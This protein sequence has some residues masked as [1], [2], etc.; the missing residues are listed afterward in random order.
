MKLLEKLKTTWS[1]GIDIFWAYFALWLARDGDIV[2]GKAI[3]MV[4][5]IK[6]LA[7]ASEQLLPSTLR[8]KLAA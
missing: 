8:S 1:R 3:L 5:E 6:E 2:L 7:G 4:E